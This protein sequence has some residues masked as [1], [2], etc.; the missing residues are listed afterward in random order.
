MVTEQRE[1][2]GLRHSRPL[3]AVALWLQLSDPVAMSIF[4]TAHVKSSQ[5]T[6]VAVQLEKKLEVEPMAAALKI[7]R[8]SVVVTE[9]G[10][11]RNVYIRGEAQAG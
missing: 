10:R 2:G 1:S 8:F 6:R 4:Y 5:T 3:L 9:M 7:Q 11:I